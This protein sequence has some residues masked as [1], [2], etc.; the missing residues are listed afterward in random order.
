MAR[1][2]SESTKDLPKFLSQNGAGYFYYRDKQT[3]TT[4]GLGRDRDAAIRY[5]D[6]MNALM[7]IGKS[8][9][10]ADGYSGFAG[11]LTAEYI[12]GMAKSVKRTCGIYFLMHNRE[13]VYV[14]Q[15]VNCH[16]R[17]GTHL[18]DEMKVFDSYFI[19]E[20]PANRLDELEAKYIVQLR[21][22]YNLAIPK[23][24]SEI[25]KLYALLE[26]AA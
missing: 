22:K 25:T 3:G 26:R 12:L 14:G 21:P 11:T 23:V 2:R 16:A 8:D 4:K 1:H 13:I 18:N 10:I 20:C 6:R 9:S 15:S 5:A 19:I 17:M 7:G 24:A